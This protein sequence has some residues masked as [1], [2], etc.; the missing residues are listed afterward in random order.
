MLAMLR[1]APEVRIFPLMTLMLQP[2]PYVK[3]LI[4]ELESQGFR[5]RIERVGYEL[6]RGGNDMLRIT[7]TVSV[8]RTSAGDLACVGTI[9]G[10]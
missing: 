9:R 3:P 7:K 2:S 1:M 10:R 8:S 4:D 6:Q 5:A